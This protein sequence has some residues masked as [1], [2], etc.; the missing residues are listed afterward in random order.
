[1]SARELRES[2]RSYRREWRR[3]RGV[4]HLYLGESDTSECTQFTRP[5]DPDG[6]VRRTSERLHGV[7]RATPPSK[8]RVCQACAKQ[9]GLRR[10]VNRVVDSR[11]AEIRRSLR[12]SVK[13]I[14]TEL[15][16]IENAAPE[17]LKAA[18][19]A[20]AA[21][22]C[23]FDPVCESPVRCDVCLVRLALEVAVASYQARTADTE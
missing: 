21:L 13:R 17:L 1:M 23:V 20:A 10:R 9:I 2:K 4:W 22:V 6:V 18:T 19:D 16:L 14:D 8:D 7:R 3:K 5:T 11:L 15:G 12:E